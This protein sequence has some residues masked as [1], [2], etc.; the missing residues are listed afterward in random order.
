MPDRIAAQPALYSA[1]SRRPPS[2]N[3]GR[4]RACGYVFFPPQQYGC[5]SCGA[6]RDQIE[7]VTLAGR[8]ALHSFATVHLYQGK[9]IAFTVGV[10]LLDDGPSIRSILTCRT[11]EGL[12][13]GDRMNATFSSQ[14]TDDQGREMVELQFEK[15][16]E[17]S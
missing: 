17:K 9:G 8:G 6:P 4:C 5:E 16:G 3:G 2:L 13:A 12:K 14:G 7:S 11:D 10:I 1:D 15:S